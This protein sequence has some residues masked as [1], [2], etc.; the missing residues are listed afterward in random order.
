[1]SRHLEA[2]LKR[3][4]EAAWRRR[5]LR[6]IAANRGR[7]GPPPVAPVWPLPRHPEGP[8]EQEIRARFSRHPHWLY[9]FE[10]Q[11]M[12][13]P[14]PREAVGRCGEGRPERPLQRFQHFMPWLLQAV[15]GNLGGKRVLDIACNAGFWSLQCALL[16]AAEVIGFDARPELIAQAEFVRSVVGAKNIRFSVLDFW[17]MTPEALGGR[18]DV[19]LNLGI[20]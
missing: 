20:L 5:N 14:G 6:E 1:M 2:V 19:V 12:G 17:Q 16:G 11:G 10:F 13:F 8:G 4:S 18:F 9:A 3:L 7:P 15:G